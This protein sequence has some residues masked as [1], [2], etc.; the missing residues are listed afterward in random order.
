VIG[1]NTR[2]EVKPILE[3]WFAIASV[4]L[5]IT[6]STQIRATCERTQAA[7]RQALLL[8]QITLSESSEAL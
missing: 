2:G 1:D 5:A 4:R 3:K 6:C 7:T 8:R